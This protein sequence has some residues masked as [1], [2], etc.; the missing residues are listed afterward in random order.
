M[1]GSWDLAGELVR[2]LRRPSIDRYETLDRQIADVL[3]L[4]S[5]YLPEVDVEIEL[6]DP[7]D[8][9]VISAAVAGAAEAIVTGDRDLLDDADLGAWLRERRI[10]VITAA[11]LLERL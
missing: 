7:D 3:V 2:V 11:E 6:H 9:P 1:V 5:P 4:L 8:A 10:E